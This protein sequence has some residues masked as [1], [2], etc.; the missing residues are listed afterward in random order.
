MAFRHPRR[1]GTWIVLGCM[2]AWGGV[3]PASQPL[4]TETARLPAPGHGHAEG[5]LEFQTSADGTES[6]VPFDFE[7]GILDRLE[8]AVEP[9]LYTSISPDKDTSASGIGDTEVTLSRL[10][11]PEEGWRPA[12]ALGADVKIPTA[13]NDLIGTGQTDF[14]TLLIASKLFGQVD[15][16]ANLGYT[17]PGSPPGVQLKNFFD[18]ALAAEYHVNPE[19]D[20]VTEVIGNQSS[21][22]KAAGTQGG[23][24]EPTLTP[25]AAGNEAIGMIGARYF[26]A[27][28]IAVAFGVTYDNNH[29]WLFR[30]GMTWSF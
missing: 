9:V 11:S 15:V 22:D 1:S 3:A 24:G 13:R 16:H 23:S 12:F 28:N 6:A 26:P 8:L 21:L 27:R 2:L 29:A 18:Y 10:V 25:E 19:L 30:P 7:Y 4:E 20:L 5:A 17:F 14:R